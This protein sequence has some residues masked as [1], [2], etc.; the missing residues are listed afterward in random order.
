VRNLLLAALGL[1][2]TLTLHRAFEGRLHESLAVPAEVEVVALVP[3]GH[4][5]DCFGPTRRRP[6]DEVAFADRRGTPSR[7]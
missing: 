4:P 1:G 7:G 6:L 5:T 2:K 3:L